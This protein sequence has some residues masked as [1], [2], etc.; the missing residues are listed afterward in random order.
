[1]NNKNLQTGRPN[2]ATKK[3]KN[4]KQI[5]EKSQ[6]N[7]NSELFNLLQDA[8]TLNMFKTIST[9]SAKQIQSTG[10]S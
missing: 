4:K 6:K 5:S 7:L 1:M 2:R 3:T 9:W 10:I 8:S